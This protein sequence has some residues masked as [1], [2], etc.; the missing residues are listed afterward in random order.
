MTLP[1]VRVVSRRKTPQITHWWIDWDGE[2]LGPFAAERD[3]CRRAVDMVDVLWSADDSDVTV[4]DWRGMASWFAN[5]TASLSTAAGACR[6]ARDALVLHL[7]AGPWDAQ[8]VT[9]ALLHAGQWLSPLVGPDQNIE[10]HGDY[11]RLVMGVWHL[12]CH[13]PSRSFAFFGINVL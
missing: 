9:D 5:D 12:N 4:P 11:I 7:I 10:T 6:A 2:R 1:I 13:V 3:A 8:R